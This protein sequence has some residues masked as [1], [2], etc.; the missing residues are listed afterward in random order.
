M[1]MSSTDTDRAGLRVTLIFGSDG[2]GGAAD[3]ATNGTRPIRRHVGRVGEHP[4]IFLDANMRYE[5]Y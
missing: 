5:E 4:K 1:D 2:R 3:N